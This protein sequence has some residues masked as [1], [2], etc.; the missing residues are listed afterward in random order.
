MYHLTPFLRYINLTDHFTNNFYTK[1]YDCRFIYVIKGNG[2][3]L[4]EYGDFT[5]SQ[6]SL[7][8]YPCGTSY[9]PQITD[10]S[11]KFIT[12]NFDFTNQYSHNKSCLF[13]VA[14]ESFKN[15]LNQPTYKSIDN[16]IFSTPF[17]VENIPY[18]KDDLLRLV[19]I[20]AQITPYTE[21]ICS[22][23]L[24]T[25]LYSIL[26]ESEKT[27]SSNSI[28]EKIQKYIEKYYAEEINNDTIANELKYH[29]YYINS[30]F[31][32]HVGKTI[33]KYLMEYRI[34]RSCELLST[35]NMSIQEIAFSCGF[36]SQPHFSTYFKKV[37]NT[38]PLDYRKKFNL[39]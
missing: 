31:K 18:I 10:S 4:T 1:A 30:V 37:N 5:L 28:V 20:H 17:V 15:E 3:L 16:P 36:I 2:R 21:H 34:N 32:Q 13:P 38:S 29:S 26:H 14:S 25:I 6:N 24:A 9:L 39:V 19:K 35:T 22:S 12:V 8:Y 27:S 7:A 33:H 11:I 23:I